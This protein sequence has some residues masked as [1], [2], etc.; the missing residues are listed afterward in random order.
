MKV[1]EAMMRIHSAGVMHCDF[2]E[3]HVLI[4]DKNDIRIID[5][6]NA[7]ESHH[8]EQFFDIEAYEYVPPELEY[9]CDELWE[10]ASGADIW[11]AS[12]SRRYQG[13]TLRC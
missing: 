13:G 4:N 3:H 8:C 1:I 5:F 6:D 11:T 9:K 10:I 12:E 2:G 7:Y